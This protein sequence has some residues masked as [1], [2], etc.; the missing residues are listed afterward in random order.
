MG[1]VLRLV[2]TTGG[3]EERVGRARERV[4]GAIRGYSAEAIHAEHHQAWNEARRL[5][6][7][8]SGTTSVPWDVNDGD[9]P[10]EPTTN[11]TGLAGKRQR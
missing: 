1:T 3:P 6:E 2:R 7:V 5:I 9:E 11:E 8:L 10:P 4:I